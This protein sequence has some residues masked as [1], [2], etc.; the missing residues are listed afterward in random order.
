MPSAAR[1]HI[2]M[3]DHRNLN[4]DPGA[5]IGHV[6]EAENGRLRWEKEFI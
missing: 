5:S 2:Q 6:A 4:G 1:W 3:V